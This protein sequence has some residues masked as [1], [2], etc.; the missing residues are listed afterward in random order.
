MKL[1]ILKTLIK[2][3]ISIIIIK[4]LWIIHPFICPVIKKNYQIHIYCL[5]FL[6]I[7]LFSIFIL[8]FKYL[9]N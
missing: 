6:K 2:R 1:L 9:Y 5:Y 3:N 7:I 8:I 4:K